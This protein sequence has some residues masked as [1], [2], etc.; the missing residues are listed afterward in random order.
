MLKRRSAIHP[1]HATGFR[2][3]SITT[4]AATKPTNP[5]LN[6]PF[7]DLP[8][9]VGNTRPFDDRCNTSSP[10]ATIP[11][12]DNFTTNPFLFK[13]TTANTTDSEAGRSHQWD[14][15]TTVE[16]ANHTDNIDRYKF[17]S[18]Q[19][20][21]RRLSLDLLK[22]PFG[23]H[24]RHRATSA[25]S[26]LKQ[27]T[28]SG[29]HHSPQHEEIL[30]SSRDTDLHPEQQ[31]SILDPVEDPLGERAILRS[32]R[33]RPEEVDDDEEEEYEED[34]QED[35]K[36][37]SF[38]RGQPML[39]ERQEQHSFNPFFHAFKSDP[40]VGNTVDLCDDDDDDDEG[41]RQ[42]WAADRQG[43]RQ[44][45]AASCT[46]GAPQP[47]QQSCRRHSVFSDWSIEDYPRLL[48]FQKKQQESEEREQ[49]EQC[50][51][52]KE[53]MNERIFSAS[54][55]SMSRST[56]DTTLDH[57]QLQPQQDIR[58]H[59]RHTS[60]FSRPRTS[61][62]PPFLTPCPR[63]N[64]A[65]VGG[66]T[67]QTQQPRPRS[68][69]EPIKWS[70]FETKSPPY[71]PNSTVHDDF[72]AQDKTNE[73]DKKESRNERE[74]WNE[75]ESW[76]E[77]FTSSSNRPF[78]W[79]PRSLA[80]REV[81]SYAHDFTK[82]SG[83]ELWVPCPWASTGSSSSPTSPSQ[84]RAFPH[85]RPD[86]DP[87]AYATS[88]SDSFTTTMVTR[89][90]SRRGYHRRQ[91]S[92]H[93][94]PYHDIREVQMRPYGKEDDHGNEYQCRYQDQGSE[95]HDRE[96]YRD[97]TEATGRYD[98]VYGDKAVPA[99]KDRLRR[100]DKDHGVR[101]YY[102]SLSWQADLGDD[103]EGHSNNHDN[104]N[105][106][107]NNG[108]SDDDHNDN[109]DNDNDDNEALHHS[110]PG[111]NPFHRP[112]GLISRQANLAK[113]KFY[114]LLKHPQHPHRPLQH[115]DH[116]RD[117]ERERE[118]E[119]NHIL[120][121]N[122]KIN[123]EEKEAGEEAGKEEEE[124][125]EVAGYLEEYDDT[126]PSRSESS[127]YSVTSSLRARMRLNPKTK[128][129][130][131]QVKRRITTAARTVMTEANKAVNTVL[132]E[133]N[134]AKISVSAAAAAAAS[135]TGKDRRK[136][137]KKTNKSDSLEGGPV[138]G[139]SQE[140]G[141]GKGLGRGADEAEDEDEEDAKEMGAPFLDYQEYYRHYSDGIEGRPRRLTVSGAR[142]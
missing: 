33:Y 29:P 67:I 112:R 97:E 128:T 28:K 105:Y 133:A 84:Y 115:H 134:K 102:N 132:S 82:D 39:V 119:P 130:L 141:E 40:K 4:T 108:N 106:N 107:N 90:P 138:D 96:R 104:C 49:E 12:R 44:S 24:R 98:R 122:H 140:W 137:K 50:K 55:T 77:T 5:S 88:E 65:A 27:L 3:K 48:A 131:S 36:E 68:L 23:W 103:S 13:P 79:C 75:K 56:T 37:P 43:Y 139:H 51:K 26:A 21:T 70:H 52:E 2:S 62:P 15:F 76:N 99:Q 47:S 53:Q 35:I 61:S 11:S 8:T 22:V 69:L 142:R 125:E 38:D 66:N 7:D 63:R 92:Y 121:S 42:G 72:G 91:T 116:E 74:P 117:H 46:G 136:K 111:R 110:S 18:K 59:H 109:S 135:T 95:D 45:W 14:N 123:K 124:E 64:S 80:R 20:R 129:T 89:S 118:H 25:S 85:E 114:K 34:E 78:S 100:D 113:A 31:Q 60:A 30:K 1:S 54:R 41:S 73:R 10:H 120:I 94:P 57:P 32:A 93:E 17:Q 19:E 86:Y 126:D 87:G 9:N 16:R 58:K 71:E 83:P 127:V 101:Y 81:H 6:S